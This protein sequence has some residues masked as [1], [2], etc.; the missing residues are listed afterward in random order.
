VGG[1]LGVRGC[2]IGGVW[3]CQRGL[4]GGR[5]G[6]DERD[7]GK[8]VKYPQKGDQQREAKG[9]GTYPPPS[10]TKPAD[11][12][13]APSYD[14]HPLPSSSSHAPAPSLNQ[15]SNPQ[16]HR[17]HARVSSA[18]SVH[19]PPTSNISAN[20]TSDGLQECGWKGQGGK[21]LLWLRRCL[22]GRKT[23]A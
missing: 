8:D 7:R 13:A 3:A 10:H 2:P 4:L 17:P 5:V 16:A 19:P 6:T 1:R 14:L 18:P 23:Q 15:T 20:I 21:C 9:C 22:S 12:S 11:K